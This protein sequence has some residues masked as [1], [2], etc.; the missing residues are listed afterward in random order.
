MTNL[1]SLSLCLTSTNVWV[2][3]PLEAGTGEKEEAERQ[4]AKGKEDH[5][6]EEGG[7]G[8]PGAAR[9]GPKHRV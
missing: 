6:R 2:A 4:G 1:L 5:G 3:V 8:Q 9:T 7:R